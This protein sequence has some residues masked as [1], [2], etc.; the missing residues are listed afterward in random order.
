MAALVTL[1]CCSVAR[2]ALRNTPSRACRESTY[3]R[4]LINN[5]RISSVLSRRH[6]ADKQTYDRSKPHVNIGTIGHVDHGKTTLTAAITK[7]LSEQGTSGSTKFH[8]YDEIDKAPEERKRGITINSAHVE[9]ETMT[10]HY[11]HTD[12]PGH[13]DY[14]KNMITGAAQME[15]A[16]L[17][18][19]ADDGQMPQTREHL[20]LA[21]QIGMEKIV[22]YINKADVVDAEVLELVEMEMREVLSEFGFDGDNSPIITGSALYA[23]EGRDPK[24]GEESIKALLAAVDEYIPLPVRELDKPFMMPVES[25]HSIPGRGTVVTGRVERGIIKKGDDVEFIGHNAK[26]KSIITGIETF[27]K[28]LGTGEAGDQLGALCRGLKRDEIKRGMVL[29]KPGSLKA[30]QEIEAQVYFLSKEEGGR[31]KP[32]TTNYTPVMFSYTWDTSARISLPEDKE[33]VM[34]GEDIKVNMSLLK[35]MVTE[36]GQRFTLRDGKITIGTGVITSILP[37]AAKTA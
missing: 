3:H 26:L 22:V 32:L 34:P 28:T 25:V 6:Y 19:A 24:L 27:H 13:L 10:R 33:M 29:C 11:A 12:C 9:Y 4:Q 17:V 8:K 35:P 36:I 16:I 7:V 5:T 31:H 21:K 14:I 20:L 23:M 1:R 37:D 15:G 2:L 18:V 30:H